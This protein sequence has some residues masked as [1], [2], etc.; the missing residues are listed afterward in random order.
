MN[1]VHLTASTFFGGP[2]RQM[3]GLAY[4]LSDRARTTFVS[5]TEG[6]RCREFLNEVR[7]HNFDTLSLQNDTPHIFA[8]I[9]EIEQFLRESNTDV[10]LCHGYKSIL[11]GRFAARRAGIPA[12]AVSRGWTGQN[13]KVRMYEWLER[14][15]LPLMDRVVCV[16]E[17]QAEKVRRWCAMPEA[18]ICVI[19]NSARIDAFS[20][21]DP[22]ARER[23]LAFFPSDHRPERTILAAGRLSPEKGF[24]VLVEAASEILRSDSTAGIVL[25]GE[26]EE[27]IRLESRLDALGLRNRFVMPGFR[28]D[29]DSLVPAADVVVLSSFTEGLPNILLEASAAGVPVVATVVGGCSE[30]VAHGET[31]LLVPSGQPASLAGAVSNLLRDPQLRRR[32]GDAGRERMREKFTFEAQASAYLNLFAA[33]KPE[34]VAA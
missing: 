5:F 20:Q 21:P 2:E 27:R 22:R 31:G 25:F 16:S 28:S 24:A 14:R 32:M 18:K 8:A 3:L 13:R 33:L 10:L 12:I 4:A 29:L 6:G 17:G 9:G 26:G 11:L 7:T 15:T 19:P 1:L 34:L 30:V 23:L